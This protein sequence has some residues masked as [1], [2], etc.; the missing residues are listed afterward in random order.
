MHTIARALKSCTISRGKIRLCDAM[1]KL[2]F[3]FDTNYIN[4]G[5]WAVIANDEWVLS[6]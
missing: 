2:L 6:W 3:I 5:I 1:G 4:D